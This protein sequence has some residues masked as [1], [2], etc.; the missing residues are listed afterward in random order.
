MRRSILFLISF[1]LAGCASGARPR[2][3]RELPPPRPPLAAT[4]DTNDPQAYYDAGLRALESDLKRAADAFFWASRLDP[5][6]ADALYARRVALHAY[7]IEK[8]RGYLASNDLGPQSVLVREIDSLF[9]AALDRNPFLYAQFDQQLIELASTKIARSGFFRRPLFYMG[10]LQYAAWKAYSEGNFARAVAQYAE[11]LK[12][13]TTDYMLHGARARAFY[14]MQEYDSA[15][16][17][18]TR[19]LDRA[20]ALESRRITPVYQSKGST[21]YAIALLHLTRGDGYSAQSA[22]QRALAEDLAHY[23]AHAV[24]ADVS[25][26]LGDTATGLAEYDLAVQLEGKD[27]SLRYRYGSALLNARQLDAAEAQF[28]RAIEINP[29]YASPYLPLAYVLERQGKPTEAAEHYARYLER[30]PRALTAQITVAR[31]RLTDLR[32]SA[33]AP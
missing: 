16:A 15:L 5:G 28:R 10:A 21:E 25:I 29:D 7:N 2:T 18:M 33:P 6:S 20:R 31:E 26:S 23:M 14:Q 12:R 22:L 17:E 19:L 4:A 32:R 9:Y 24:L 3:V 30:A 13:D 11:A 1:L 27:A 8:V